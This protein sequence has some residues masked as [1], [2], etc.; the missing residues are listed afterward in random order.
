LDIDHLRSLTAA[1][2]RIVVDTVDQRLQ[3]QPDVTTRN[4]KR[5]HPNP[6]APWE[7][8]IGDLRVF[9]DVEQDPEQV[10]TILAVGMKAGNVLRVGGKDFQL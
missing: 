1:Q 4:R 10:V 6:L 7:L 5:L 3:D 8:R 2:Q 9:Y